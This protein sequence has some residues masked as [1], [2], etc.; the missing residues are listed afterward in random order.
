MERMERGGGALPADYAQADVTFHLRIA[1]A[2][3]NRAL[4]TLMRPI[5]Q[6]LH[7]RIMAV[8]SW[9]SSAEW[10]NRQ[11]RRIYEAVA[12]RDPEAARRAMEEHLDH[13]VGEVD[14]LGRAEPATEP[15]T[16]TAGAEQPPKTR[17]R[18][19]GGRRAEASG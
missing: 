13:V 5:L 8:L 4:A 12:A 9:P 11:H 18:R 1:I 14:R 3:H 7:G 10:S 2:A 19:G 16:G 17:R 6:P 15:A